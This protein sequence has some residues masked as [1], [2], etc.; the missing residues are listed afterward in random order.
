MRTERHPLFGYGARHCSV[1]PGRKDDVVGTRCHVQIALFALAVAVAT[2]LAVAP[3]RASATSLEQQLRGTRAELRHAK[4]HLAGARETLDA[5]VT[6]HQKR[7]LGS[8]VLEV[9][10]ARHG[11]RF[12]TAVVD[13]LRAERARRAA[14]KAG[15]G[16]GDWKTLCRRAATKHGVSADGLY[17]LLM[18]ESG[19]RARAVGA[20]R[21]YGLF[22]YTLF[23]WRSAWNPWRGR[24]VFDGAAQIEASAYAVSKGMGYSLWGNTYPVAF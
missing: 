10:K 8:L 13:D 11:V 9:R 17:R 6:A 5:A 18:M 24:D 22:Q 12:W 2:V 1:E 20:G 4:A 7:G 3:A 21:Y 19:G 16:G 23:T 15:A 14:V